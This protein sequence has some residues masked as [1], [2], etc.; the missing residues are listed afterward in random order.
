MV[1]S[2]IR[3]I[4]LNL[5]PGIGSTAWRLLL[6]RLGGVEGIG[7]ADAGL[8]RAAG[9]SPAKAAAVIAIRDDAP[10]ADEELAL[11]ARHGTRIVTWADDGYPPQLRTIP[12]PPLALY[13]RGELCAGDR[14]AVAVVGAR[15]ASLYGLQCAARFGEELAARGITV[16]SGLALGI[17][18]AAHEGALRAGGRTVAVLGGGLARLYPPQ[19]AALAEQVAAHGAVISEYPMTMPSLP[20][21]FPRRNRIISGLSLGVVVVEAASRSGSLITADCALE[22]GREVFAVPGPVMSETSRGTHRLVRQGAAL[23][24]CAEDVLDELGLL[25]LDELNARM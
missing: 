22:Q 12:D 9:L 25:D 10:K 16:V 3:C 8:L 7:Q 13:V 24:T 19:H 6:D 11:A 21:Q 17:D 23:V 18:G 15:R 1:S 20:E 4:L 5:I 2:R 14:A